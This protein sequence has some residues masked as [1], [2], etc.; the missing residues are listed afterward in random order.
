MTPS[1]ARVN[2]ELAAYH[3]AGHAVS[4]VRN[5]REVE[6]VSVSFDRPGEGL[7]RFS[8]RL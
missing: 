5:G 6:S 7:T 4:A 2:I 8:E 1:D 3:E